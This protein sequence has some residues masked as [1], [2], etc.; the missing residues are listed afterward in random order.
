[1]NLRLVIVDD[2]ALVRTGFKVILTATHN[3]DVVATCD[4]REAVDTVIHHDPDVVLLDVR[5]PEVDGLTVLRELRRRSCRARVAMLTTFDTEEY[6]ATALRLGATG[7]LLKDTDPEQLPEF[8]RIIASGGLVLANSVGDIFTS[9]NLWRQGSEED[10][11]KI[12]S[13]SAREREV[14]ALVA[15]G[16]TNNEIAI[17]V[18]LSPMT[19]KDHVSAILTKLGSG[20]RVQAAVLAERTGLSASSPDE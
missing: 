17:R 9:G 20:S 5:M 2:E 19:I 12:G 6:V 8:V 7:F 10:R 13:L 18:H 16:L 1:M 11:R 3:M 14:L 4:G 15:E